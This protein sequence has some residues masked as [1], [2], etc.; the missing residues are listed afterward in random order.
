MNFFLYTVNI[1]YWLSLDYMTFFLIFSYNLLIFAVNIAVAN[2]IRCPTLPLPSYDS[3]PLPTPNQ[4]ALPT[5]C[6]YYL[7]QVSYY[8]Y[9]FRIII[10]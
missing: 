8:Y 10:I 9:L 5:T 3:F 7:R 1:L 4:S 2:V 6:L